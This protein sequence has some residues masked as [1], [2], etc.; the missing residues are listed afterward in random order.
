VSGVLDPYVVSCGANPAIFGMLALLTVELFQSWSVVPDRGKHLF[1]LLAMILVGFILGSLPYVDNLAQ[2]GGFCFGLVAS[3]V[4]LP[5]VT[6][7]KWH[8][9]ARFLLLVVCVPLLLVMI[10]VGIVMF[11]AVQVTD[12]FWCADFN[13]WEWTSDISCDGSFT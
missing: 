1:K 12:C 11:Y 6:L 4:F 8:A 5:Y 7:G 3:V 9:R 13:C 10:V 2:L